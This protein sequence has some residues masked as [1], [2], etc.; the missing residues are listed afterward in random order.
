MPL[1]VRSL[2]GAGGRRTGR[3]TNTA[4]DSLPCTRPAAR[5]Q[6]RTADRPP[7]RRPA[8]VRAVPWRVDVKGFAAAAL[9]PV[10]SRKGGRSHPTA[11]V[12]R[13]ARVGCGRRLGQYAGQ[14]AAYAFGFAAYLGGDVSALGDEA[15][16]D[17]SFLEHGAFCS[18]SG[19]R[20]GPVATRWTQH[21]VEAELLHQVGEQFLHAPLKSLT[22]VGGRRVAVAEWITRSSTPTTINEDVEVPAQ[23]VKRGG[24]GRPSEGATCRTSL[25]GRRPHAGRQCG[26][27]RLWYVR[28]ARPD[29]S[30]RSVPAEDSPTAHTNRRRPS[31]V[32]QRSG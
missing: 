26:R 16:E 20:T 9:A 27:D 14:V 2:T 15:A 18:L 31:S 13:C 5:Q 8:P 17:G 19:V 1:T 6:Q 10:R 30:A 11:G 12:V 7:P 25:T 32:A 29:T 28:S 4:S 22:P 21:R 23:C 24:E 3:P